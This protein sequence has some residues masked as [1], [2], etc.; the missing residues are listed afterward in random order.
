MSAEVDLKVQG[1]I[2]ALEATLGH[3]I[4]T[5]AMRP[6]HEFCIVGRTQKAIADAKAQ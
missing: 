2:K 5:C 4:C 3:L 6:H 1:L